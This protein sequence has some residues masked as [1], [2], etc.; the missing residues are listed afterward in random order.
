MSWDKEVEQI[1]DRR[2]WAKIQGGPE[3]VDRH[4]AK[5]RLTIRERIDGVLDTGSFAE[6]GEMAGSAELDAH[7]NV[8]GY[9]P[10]NYVLGFGEIDGRR[11]A[12]GG[13]D[14]TLKG[15]SPNAAGLRRSVYAEDIA[16]QYKVPLVR[17]LEGGGGSVAGSSGGG[18]NFGPVFSRARFKSFGD[19][20]ATVPVAAAACGPVAGFPAARLVASHFSVMTEKTAQVLVAGP[21]V[22]E[23][24][25]GVAMTKEQLGGSQVHLKN[26]VVDNLAK[27]EED[28]FRQ[29]RTFLGYLPSNV[30]ELPPVIACKDPV[31]R[32]EEELLSIIPR[33]RRK[34]YNGRK[35][36]KLI[37]DKDSFFEMGRKFGPGQITGLARLNGRP[38]G[39]LSADCKYLAGS[40]TADG[41]QKVRRFIDLC[42]TFHLPI[43]SL[44]DEPGFMIGPDAEQAATIRYGTAFVVAAMQSRVPWAS[45]VIRKSFGVAAAGH[46]GPDGTIFAWPSA[47][48]GALPVEGG[49]AVAFAKEIAAADDPDA[50][51]AELEQEMSQAGAMF[52]RA[53]QFNIHDLIDPRETRARL[54]AWLDISAPLLKDQLGPVGYTIRP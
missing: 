8:I 28:A 31:D 26:G 47:E 37:V 5:G 11:V 30:W 7:D 29:I 32:A 45:I 1:R 41:S 27:D 9:S 10:A 50:K 46:Y 2:K 3:G 24:A 4:H 17:F 48:M 21:A 6:Q 15:G 43:I 33:D 18:L 36:I 23:R 40:M 35:V 51:R 39:I 44:V 38:V 34:I 42:D 16:I 19:A 52:Q 14:F 12:I 25:L 54:C 53:E 22:V 20:M 13:E 49:V